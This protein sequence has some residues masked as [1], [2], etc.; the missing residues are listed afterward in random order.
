MAKVNILNFN[1][2][3][4]ILNEI[5]AQA[6]G[7]KGIAPINESEFVSVAQATLQTGY[8]PVINAISQVLGRTI[9]SVRPY[10]RKFKGLFMDEMRFGA[11]VRKLQSIDKPFEEDD[12]IKLTD[13]YAV[14]QQV[15]NKPAVLET[16]Y[17]GQNVYQKSITIFRDQLDT[18]FSSSAEFGKF[19]AMVMQNI[20]DQIEQAHENTARALVSN[21]IGAKIDIAASDTGKTHVIYLVD[22]YNSETGSSLTRAQIL[23]GTYFPEFAKWLYGFLKTLSGMMSE[24]SYEYHMDIT[25]KAIA[26]HTPVRMQKMY[27]FTPYVNRVGASVL[28]DVY[29]DE[30]LQYA[31]HEE[32]N[33][34]QA[35]KA[36]AQI[37]VT[38]A[39]ID[40]S[41]E[42]EDHPTAVT[43]DYVLG[44]LFD[45][46][47]AGITT[48]N[49]WTA[50][51]PFNARGGYTN[52]FWH[53]TDRYNLDVTENAVVLLLDTAEGSESDNVVGT[54]VVGT[55]TAG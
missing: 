15:V 43:A 13:G 44:V 18:A 23:S 16:N 41:G 5:N 27:L 12:R 22:A 21:L 40:A 37:S 32:V 31:D 9:F 3:A 45:E 30:L 54:A 11:R 26:R 50:A 6:T 39:Y 8:D 19:V 36:P 55:A 28:A 2:L 53:F 29:H 49:Q 17:Y 47:A 48:V 35:I 34:W 20:E 46:E 42:I 33:Y 24:R 7:S 52:F 38:P 4:T 51:A 25:N 10:T 1:Q 14:D